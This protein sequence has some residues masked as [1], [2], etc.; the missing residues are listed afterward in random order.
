MITTTLLAA[1]LLVLPSAPVQAA[2]AVD[3]SHG[4][5]VVCAS[6]EQ[7]AACAHLTRAWDLMIENR[8]REAGRE[9]ERAV[10][11]RQDAGQYAGEELWQLAAYQFQEGRIRGAVRTLDRMANEAQRVGDL[12]RQ[13]RAL[14]E[15]VTL[16]AQLGNREIAAARLDR[17]RAL[18]GS[19]YLPVATADHVRERLHGV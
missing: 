8:R 7:D 18:L 13:A 2:G 6:A 3:A 4:P 1:T 16:H 14:T 17:V 19:P 11:A 15:A 10:Q 5:W 12:D 9:L